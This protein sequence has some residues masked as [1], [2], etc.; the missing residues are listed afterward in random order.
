MA[1]QPTTTATAA[2]KGI[3]PGDTKSVPDI[4]YEIQQ[5]ARQLEAL[6]VAI[7]GALDLESGYTVE[8]LPERIDRAWVL[9]DL[10]KEITPKI[11]DMAEQIELAGA[12]AKFAAA[13]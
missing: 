10:H 5:R 6:V 9:V 3:A 11:I 2:R 8:S 4:A 12:H 1:T 7:E 13:A